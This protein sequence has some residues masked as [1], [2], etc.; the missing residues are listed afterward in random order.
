VVRSAWLWRIAVTTSAG[1]TA[2][3]ALSACGV[4]ERPTLAEASA[5]GGET[6][7]PTGIPAADAVLER[8]EGEPASQF[9]ADYTITTNFG[10]TTR[11]AEVVRSGDRTSVTIGD[12]RFLNDGDQRTC[13]LATG[14]CMAGIQESHVSDAA[15]TSQFAAGSPAR[16]LRVSL[17]RRSRMPSASTEVIAGQP[18][19]CVT[20]PVGQGQEVTCALP[21]GVVGRWETAAVKVELTSFSTHA[22]PSAFIIHR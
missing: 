13:D 5:V 4:G 17:A 14:Q 18:I 15:V 1:L 8:L 7:T 3:L 12:V 2:V 20:V 16:Q 19:P 11:D 9:T 21:E 6:G 22:D 10:N